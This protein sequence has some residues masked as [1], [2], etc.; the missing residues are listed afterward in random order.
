MDRFRASSDLEEKLVT[1]PPPGPGPSG[2]RSVLTSRPDG[3]SWLRNTGEVTPKLGSASTLLNTPGYEPSLVAVT[4]PLVQPGGRTVTPGVSRPGSFWYTDP[5]T[6]RLPGRRKPPWSVAD[7][8]LAPVAAI[9]GPAAVTT[10]AS[11]SESLGRQSL[12]SIVSVTSSAGRVPPSPALT[13]RLYPGRPC[14]DG[15]V[16]PA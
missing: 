1:R 15:R 13:Q 5:L 16:N 4:Q 11:S 3:V 10:T 14:S 12:A 2:T 6:S 8:A 7:A 9:T